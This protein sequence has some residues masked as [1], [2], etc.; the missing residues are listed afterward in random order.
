MKYRII[1]TLVNVLFYMYFAAIGKSFMTR[2]TLMSSN[3]LAFSLN[4]K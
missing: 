4:K 3:I 1:S 2:A